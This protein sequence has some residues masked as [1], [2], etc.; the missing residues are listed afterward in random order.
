MA[1][2]KNYFKD[3]IKDYKKSLIDL[4]E[5]KTVNELLD[6]IENDKDFF[7]RKKVSGKVD[8]AASVLLLSENMEKGLFLFHKKIKKWTM[9]GGHADGETDL[10]K[11]ALDELNEEVDILLEKNSMATPKFIYKY[12]YPAEVFGYE[13]SII[14]LFYIEICPNDQKPKIMEPNKCE[15]LKWMS[16]YEVKKM[17][18]K[19]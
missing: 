16:L 17:A 3:V 18:K 13:K 5:M 4:E 11:V 19:K 7:I 10:Y 9:P 2:S 14:N 1:M 6:L 15:E 8:V 12:N